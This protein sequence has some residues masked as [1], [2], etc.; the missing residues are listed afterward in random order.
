[1]FGAEL[2][3]LRRRVFFFLFAWDDSLLY[4]WGPSR[5]QHEQTSLPGSA[6]PQRTRPCRAEDPEMPER[7]QSAEKSVS[8]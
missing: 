2:F 6:P 1:M 3:P 7:A 5:E 4:T 8:C